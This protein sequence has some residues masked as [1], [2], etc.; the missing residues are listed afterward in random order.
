[1]ILCICLFLV[2]ALG[3]QANTFVCQLEKVKDIQFFMFS[4]DQALVVGVYKDGQLGV[5]STTSGKR[6]QT[7]QGHRAPYKGLAFLKEE[8]ILV[9]IAKDRQMKYWD[10]VSGKLLKEV[11]LHLN[12]IDLL[13]IDRDWRFLAVSSSA[14][15]PGQQNA[16]IR[17]N[18]RPKTWVYSERPN[19][20]HYKDMNIHIFDIY[21]GLKPGNDGHVET[22][23]AHKNV[24]TALAFS[25]DSLLVSGDKN[26]EIYFWDK[27]RWSKTDSLSISFISTVKDLYYHQVH[28][29]ILVLK[30]NQGETYVNM[31][32]KK[33][34]SLKE[35]PKEFQILPAI[36]QGDNILGFT[37]YE[38]D[39]LVI[40][41]TNGIF[42]WKR[43]DYIK[44]LGIKTS[45]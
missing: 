16:T 28:D 5:W 30:G 44:S 6:L 9:S 45:E 38:Y 37:P 34:L 3:A 29:D 40:Q 11:T 12:E 27:E 35:S 8:P 7:Y 32:S 2:K 22:L 13:A 43:E 25:K 21:E 26:G 23:R 42:I 39:H 1:M 36:M 19:E 17:P 20:T 4:H 41:N 31:P 18:G 15:R 33:I 24:I 10:V 14:T